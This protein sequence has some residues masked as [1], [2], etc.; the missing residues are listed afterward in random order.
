MLDIVK[1]GN[2]ELTSQEAFDLYSAEMYIVTYS[3][4]YQL[5]YSEAQRTVYGQPIYHEKGLA[6]RGRFYT[7][8]GKQINHLLKMQLVKEA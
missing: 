3:H 5:F 2:V 1:I 8:T 7:M 6:A 4:I